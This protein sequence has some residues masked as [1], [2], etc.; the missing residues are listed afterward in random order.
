MS[1]EKKNVVSN[2]TKDEA[3]LAAKNK[4]ITVICKAAPGSDFLDLGDKQ[5]VNG[6]RI[7]VTAEEL[8]K[9][10]AS[11]SWKFEQEKEKNNG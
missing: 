1:T 11:S 2:N 8:K 9:L 6:E 4:M 10:N 7:Q 3:K 5:L